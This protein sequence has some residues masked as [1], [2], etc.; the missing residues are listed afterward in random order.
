MSRE[1]DKVSH[2]YAFDARERHACQAV[3]L[4]KWAKPVETTFPIKSLCIK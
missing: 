2:L 1:E 4:E 3:T